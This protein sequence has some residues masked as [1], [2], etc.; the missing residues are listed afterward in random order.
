MGVR[1]TDHMGNGVQWYGAHGQW[2]TGVEHMGN[3]VQ[4]YGAHGQWGTGDNGLQ[5]TWAM[6]HSR[7]LG[8]RVWGTWAVR[9]RPSD[10]SEC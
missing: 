1:G 2:G 7:Q 3:G 4:R 5:S 9:Y 6:G 8:T 10:V